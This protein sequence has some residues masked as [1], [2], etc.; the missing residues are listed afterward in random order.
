MATDK[1]IK[2]IFR[3]NSYTL[4]L[5]SSYI[6]K[7]YLCDIYSEH[8]LKCEDDLKGFWVCKSR[9]QQKQRLGGHSL[10]QLHKHFPRALAQLGAVNICDVRGY[11]RMR[12]PVFLWPMPCALVYTSMANLTSS[13]QYL[14]LVDN[15]THNPCKQEYCGS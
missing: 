7:M 13:L 12:N 9:T 14:F 4:Y 8:S 10:T 6:F 1:S 2:V 11:R 3:I 5:I 15:S